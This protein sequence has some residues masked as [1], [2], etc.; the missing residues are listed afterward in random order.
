MIVAVTDAHTKHAKDAIHGLPYDVHAIAPRGIAAGFFLRNVK[1]KS[2]VRFHDVDKLLRLVSEDDVLMPIGF[3]RRVDLSKN[4]KRI[5]PKHL[6]G[7][8]DK[9]VKLGY[10]KYYGLM[11]ASEYLEIPR[12]RLPEEAPKRFPL[13]VKGRFGGFAYVVRNERE[14]KKAL[15]IVKD[16]MIQEYVPGRGVGYFAIARDGVIYAEYMHRRIVEYPLDGGPSV[17]AETIRIEDVAK[18]AR[19]FLESIGRT[20]PVMLEFRYDGNKAKLI[21]INA[22]FWGSLGL[23][24]AAGVNMPEIYVRLALG[25]DPGYKRGK[26][27]VRY[28]RIVPD[29]IRLLLAAPSVFLR[30]FKEALKGRVKHNV[31]SL[32]ALPIEVITG[33][34]TFFKTPRKRRL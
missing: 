19:R 6:I 24:I 17:V 33:V 25:E 31:Y 8:F 22:K 14:L 2:V 27:G 34:Y 18:D 3:E 16:P 13:V 29:G 23:G 12:T 5:K 11:K 7:E 9:T 15:E 4:V 30:W 1:R 20:G 10:D 21:E 26:T 32:R 28:F